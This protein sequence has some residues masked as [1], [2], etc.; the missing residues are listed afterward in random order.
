MRIVHISDLHFGKH[1]PSL[2]KSLLNELRR[3]QPN[4]VICTGDIGDSNDRRLFEAAAA[5]LEQVQSCCSRIDGAP[6]LI[7]VPGNHDARDHGFL[8]G[9][10]GKTYIAS[11]GT[12]ATDFYFEAH[13]LWVYG[14]DSATE[15]SI[16]GS[17]KIRDEDLNR[18]HDRYDELASQ[19]PGFA[20][21]VKVVAVHHHPLPVNWN[22][23]AKDRWLTMMNAG[24]FLSAALYR[25]VDLILHGHEHLQAR[26]RLWSTLG[27]NDHTVTV[28]SLGTTLRA[29]AAEGNWFGV[30]DIEK[31][32][33]KAYSYSSV[34]GVGS[35]RFDSEPVAPAFFVRSRH[36]SAERE[37]SKVIRGRGYYYA[38]VSSIAKIGLDGDAQRWVEFHGLHLLDVGIQRAQSHDFKLPRATGSLACFTVSGD[39]VGVVSES[40][41]VSNYGSG[42]YLAKL[43]FDRRLLGTDSVSYTCQWYALNS[44]AL[45]ESQFNYLYGRRAPLDNA[46]FT[47]YPVEDPIKELTLVV[48]LPMGMP[49]GDRKST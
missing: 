13:N 39:Q 31:D 40:P 16:G 37:L 5:Y 47:Y 42:E 49:P 19:Y 10:R 46:E 28:I 22:A 21:A 18:F 20:D 11:F 25:R 6:A 15:G 41:M 48:N 2:A 14:F 24:S 9:D 33:V 7:T 45:D 35:A 12:A 30:I 34:G 23:D 1:D 27:A 44:Y 4:L 43:R 36:E 32:E 17:G 8:F 29:K 26:A 38:R 3:I